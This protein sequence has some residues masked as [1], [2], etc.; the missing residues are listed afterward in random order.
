MAQYF[1]N[2]DDL[3]QWVKSRGSYDKAADE[4]IGIIGENE[5]PN[6][7]S[8]IVE[9]CRSIFENDDENDDY[10]SQ[11]LLGVLAKHNFAQIRKA[12]TMQKE[13]QE[14][15][16]RNDYVRGRRNKWNRTVEGYNENTPWRVDRDKMY[17]KTHYY[18]DAVTFDEDPNHVYSGEAIWRMYVADKFY[19]DYQNEEGRVVG[20][21]IN[22][23]FQVWHDVAGNQMELAAGERTRKPR[24]HQYSTERR[25]EEARGNKTSDLEAFAKKSKAIVKISSVDNKQEEDKVYQMFKDVLDMREAKIDYKEMLKAVSEHYDTTILKVAQVDRVAKQLAQKHDGIAYVADILLKKA[26]SLM[27]VVNQGL[28]GSNISIVDPS[29]AQV[30]SE[31]GQTFVLPAGA[32]VTRIPSTDLFE[33]VN[34]PQSGLTGNRISFQD[35]N[36]EVAP[37]SPIQ[38]AASEL[39][40]NENEMEELSEAA[41]QADD[42]GINMAEQPEDFDLTEAPQPEGM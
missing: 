2:S 3:R 6:E 22:D 4:L 11:V 37:T 12:G 30:I 18:T 39:G 9:T 31:N 7:K 5:F 23:R 16:Q 36:V 20:G 32:V 13:A 42:N 10:A 29:G 24:P 40:L 8:E 21:Y 27:D 17:D 34:D 35:M 33:I 41:E 28:D 25:L 38:D 14:S 1:Q 26:T 15:R 19:R